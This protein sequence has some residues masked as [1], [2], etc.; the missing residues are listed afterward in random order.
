MKVSLLTSL[1]CLFSLA[2]VAQ[3]K[4]FHLDKEYKAN[5]SGT[6]DLGSS[7]AKVYI[8]GSKR[9][10][11]HIKIYRVFTTSGVVCGDADEHFKVEV[12]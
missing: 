12:S 11:V 3:E 9:R 10:S 7:D 8:T 1:A 2:V 6:I 5:S 4:D